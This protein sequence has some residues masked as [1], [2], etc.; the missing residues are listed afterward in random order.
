MGEDWKGQKLDLTIWSDEASLLKWILTYIEGII[1]FF[2]GIL[3]AII[4][5]GIMNTMWISV[6]E[7]TNEIG[8]LRAIGM[9]RGRVLGLFLLETVLLALFATTIG[10]LAGVLLSA[11]LN[12]A[13]INI[14]SDAVRM[15]LMNQTLHLTVQPGHV[16]A[17][18]IS[19]SLV[20]ALAA[21]WPAFRA[22]QLQPIT[23][24]HYVG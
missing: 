9:S 21:L 16:I 5:I 11:A 4:G 19:L 17:S 10:A 18:I 3:M 1:Y 12:A 13:A 6:R 20:S 23:A 24:I 14:S 15:I 7:R 2:T 22:S 8:T